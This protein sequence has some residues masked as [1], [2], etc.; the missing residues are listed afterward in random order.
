MRKIGGLILTGMLATTLTTNAISANAEVYTKAGANVVSTKTI[1]ATENVTVYYIS[2]NGSD[3][4]PG[5]LDAP[6]KSLMK[7]QAEASSGDIVYI[8]EGV[9]DEFEINQTDNPHESVYHYV[10]DIYKSGIT[11]K[12]YPG[13]ERPVFDFSNVPTDQRVAAFYI[14]KEVTDINFEGFD[15]TGVKVGEQ[16]QSEAFRISGEANFTNMSAHDNEA[17]GFYYIE[18]GTGIVLNTDAYN[19]IGATARSASNTDGFGAHGK[20]VWFVNSRAWNNSDDGFDSI[21]SNG[22]VA[23]INDWAFNHHGDEN[24]VGDKNGFKVGGYAY[25]TE[26]LPN[27]IPV[28]IVINSLAANNGGNNFYANHQPG[29]SAYWLNNTAYKPGYGANFNMLERL[30]PTSKEDIP[31]NREV[32]HHNIAYEGPLTSNNNTLPENETNNSWTI[33]GGLE[34]STDDFE[35]LD[36]EQL[37][38]PREV[39]GSLPDVTFMKPVSTSPLYT[40]G[41]GYL[42]DNSVE[43]LQKLVSI[44]TQKGNI[45]NHGIENSLQKKLQHGNLNA[46]IKELKAQAGKHIDE[47]IAHVL[48]VLA[49]EL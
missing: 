9:Y 49:N 13:D 4:N 1:N 15:V 17:N 44:Y 16:K 6:F 33:D 28:H 41:L 47:D 18:N 38:A 12:A 34:V 48:T 26:G 35:S 40:N 25:R 7:A 10:H 32:L 14:G 3:S 43:T 23:Y 22:P 19:N 2:P 20:A 21:N 5:T 46:F 39:D 37:T 8:R 11:Y 31:G 27:P 30:S 29:Q 24:R 36:M 45:D 42:A